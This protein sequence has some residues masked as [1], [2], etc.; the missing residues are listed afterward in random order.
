MSKKQTQQEKFQI[1]TEKIYQEFT[2]DNQKYFEKLQL[3][4]TTAGLFYDDTE[5]QEQIF[6]IV[7]DLLTAQRDGVS[8]TEFLGTNPREMANQLVKTSKGKNRVIYFGGVLWR[9]ASCGLFN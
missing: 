9:W 1:A 2:P 3:Y 6:Q 8:A 5:V 7:A 4:L